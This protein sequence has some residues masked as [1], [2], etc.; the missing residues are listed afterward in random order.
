M[1]QENSKESGGSGGS[2]LDGQEHQ[3]HKQVN[4]DNQVQKN[5]KYHKQ[6]NSNQVPENLKYHKQGDQLLMWSRNRLSSSTARAPVVEGIAPRE[7]WPPV[8]VKKWRRVDAQASRFRT[9]NSAF[10][11]LPRTSRQGV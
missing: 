11:A 10:G 6:V 7:V 2:P 3:A 8:P 9:S 4:S 1:T 5:L